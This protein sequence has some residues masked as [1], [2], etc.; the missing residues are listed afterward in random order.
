MGLYSV[1]LAVGQIIGA[2]IGGFA[3]DARGIDGMLVAT[4]VLLARR[5]GPARPAAARRGRARPV[6]DPASPAER[7]R[8]GDRRPAVDPGP[9]GARLARR[10]RRAAPPGDRGRPARPA[11]RRLGGGRG[12]RHE[13]RPGRR[14]AQR[15]RHRRR[16]VLADLGR[17]AAGEQTALNGSGRAPAAADAAALRAQRPDGDPATRSAVDHRARAPSARGA[18]RTPGTA[19]CRRDAIL[20]PA[21]EL[22]RDGF[23]AWDG[24]I[25]A[26]EATA[27]LV[28]PR[29]APD[30]GFFARLP[31]ERPAVASRRARPAA[32][33]GRDARRAWPT[34]GFDAFYDGDLGE[35]QA[36]GLAAAGSPDRRRRPARAH[37]HLG[38]RRSPSTIAASG[39]RPIR[40][41]ARA[42]S[43]WSCSASWSRFEARRRRT[44]S[45][46]TASRT[47]RWIHLGLEAA[48]LAMAD[49]DA[50]ADRS[51]V[52]RR[53]GRAPAGPGLRIAELA[54]R[55]DPRSGGAARPRPTNPRGGGTIYLADVDG[56]GNAVSLIESN[57]MGF[58]SGVVDPDDRHPLPEPGQLLQPRPGPPERA[59][60]GQA[61]APHAA[62]RDAVPGRAMAGRSRGSS[63]GRWAATPSRR[64]TPSS[65]RPSSTA[66][67]T[68]GPRSR[69]RAGTSSRA[70]TSSR[71]P[72][73]T[74]SRGTRAGVAEALAALG[75]DLVPTAPFDG[76]LGHEH[77]IELVDGGRAAPD[78][79]VAAATDP[80][81]AGLPGRLVGPRPA[82][83]PYAI[84]G[85]GRWPAALTRRRHRPSSPEREQGGARDLERQPELPVL[86][87]V[88]GRSRRDDRPARGRARGS[89]GDA[90]R[91]VDARSTTT[92]AGGSGSARPR[93][94]RG[95]STRPATR[96]RSTPCTSSATGPA[97]RRSCAERMDGRPHRTLTADLRPSRRRAPRPT[98]SGSRSRP[99]ASGSSTACRR[100]RPASRRSRRWR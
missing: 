80:R 32:G 48:K 47:R 2:L 22:A 79:S 15:L 5:P 34:D 82:A 40:P 17:S 63:P 44:P 35:R 52:P 7:R 25:G 77:A 18:T 54:A 91:R 49:R 87:R 56:D 42:S 89:G 19:A 27:A 72:T 94:A 12:H 92:T 57:Y 1:F 71:R 66:V 36:R 95:S 26:V 16:R 46:R 4:A 53:P 33:P 39:S 51:D 84:L 100:A 74:W 86:E 76:N 31:A 37:D 8:A 85:A 41:T 3:A 88:R 9:A 67:S 64:S 45:G 62:P 73:S 14:H 58:G 13:R 99:S 69:R 61:D 70:T 97:P 43:P 10:R 29:S 30:A 6:G 83:G 90:R 93:A 60:A 50:C 38:R 11:R 98:R 78:G 55:I 59:G 65:S 21:I 24:F 96:S 68:S 81:S 23:P 28:T 75:H 20:G